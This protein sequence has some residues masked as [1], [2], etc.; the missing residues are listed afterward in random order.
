MT[1]TF[2]VESMAAANAIL[3][4]KRVKLLSKKES[5]ERLNSG[6]EDSDSSATSS[7]TKSLVLI[8]FS[9]SSLALANILF[10]KP[11]LA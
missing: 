1:L 11:Y 6:Q 7:P 8:E 4:S 10:F 2:V 9:L 5:M 3:R